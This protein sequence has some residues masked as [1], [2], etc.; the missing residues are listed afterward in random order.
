MI[1]VVRDKDSGP[2]HIVDKGAIRG[3]LYKD[4][5]ELA[6]V[7]TLCCSY[8]APP[9]ESIPEHSVHGA[10]LCRGCYVRY[11]EEDEGETE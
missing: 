11:L 2:F 3:P 7:R 10:F 6:F 1:I 4:G 9:L 5:Y 8:I